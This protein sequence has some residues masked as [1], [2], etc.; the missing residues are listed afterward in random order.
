MFDMHKKRILYIMGV[1]WNW[2]FQRPQIIAQ[3]LV[4]KCEV[5]VVF[6]RSILYFFHFRRTVMKPPK[7]S[8]ILWTLPRQ[9]RYAFLGKL[10]RILA[11]RV[12]RELEKYDAVVLGYPL[13]YRYISKSYVGKIIYDCMDY[14]AALYPDIGSLP[15]MLEMED[16]LIEESSKIVVTSSKLYRRMLEKNI[17]EQKLCL[18]RNGTSL[19]NVIPPQ[20]KRSNK[21][22][23]FKL[24]Y[25]GTIAHWFDYELLI[26]SCKRRDNIEYHLI[27]PIV[28]PCPPGVERIVMEGIVSST[29]LAEYTK[30]YDCLI[31]PFIVNDVVEWVDPVKLYEYIALGKCIISVRYAEIER[32]EPYVYMYADEIEYENLLEKLSANG[33]PAKYTAEQQRIFLNGNSWECRFEQWDAL[34]DECM[35]NGRFTE[36]KEQNEN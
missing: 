33:F 32:F 36:G 4:E 35:Q 11:K 10:S 23:V 31:M 9:E 14:Y 29:E 19:K 12:F 25:F 13:Y 17:S 15:V 7:G 21:G 8:R 1:D 27:G 2:I 3:H 18:I 16:R 22:N 26:N 5:T 28:T 20:S 6:P 34:L 24:G 30:D